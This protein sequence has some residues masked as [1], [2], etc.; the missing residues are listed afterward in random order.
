MLRYIQNRKRGSY[1]LGLK[2]TGKEIRS[3]N[4]VLFSALWAV[5]TYVFCVIRSNI[6]PMLIIRHPR[7][8]VA[9]CEGKKML[10]STDICAFHHIQCLQSMCHRKPVLEDAHI[11]L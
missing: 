3:L 7:I 6:S 10:T 2:K 5:A 1:Y 9:T 8:G 11:I 4:K